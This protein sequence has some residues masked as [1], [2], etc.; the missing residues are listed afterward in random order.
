[1][2][3]CGISL[4]LTYFSQYIG[5]VDGE[6]P[7]DI[8]RRKESIKVRSCGDERVCVYVCVCVCV[9]MFVIYCAGD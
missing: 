9:T 2:C 4:L 8:A 6:L 5:N 7:L 3:V 1:M